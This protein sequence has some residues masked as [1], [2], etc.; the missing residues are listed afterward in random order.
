MRRAEYIPAG[1]LDERR[2]RP[3]ADRTA[4][5]IGRGAFDDCRVTVYASR[6]AMLCFCKDGSAHHALIKTAVHR[7]MIVNRNTQRVDASIS[8]PLDFA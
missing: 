1:R 6:A 3:D 2:A 4:Y 7:N 8:L 5:T